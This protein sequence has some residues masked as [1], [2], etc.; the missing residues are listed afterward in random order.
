MATKVQKIDDV[1]VIDGQVYGTSE[2]DTLFEIEKVPAKGMIGQF[3]RALFSLF[4]RRKTDIMEDFGVEKSV[5]KGLKYLFY[6]TLLLPMKI[7]AGIVNPRWEYFRVIE[8][9][10]TPVL[11]F[12]QGGAAFAVLGAH[13]ERLIDIMRTG[14]GEALKPDFSSIEQVLYAFRFRRIAALAVAAVLLF[15]G[16]ALIVEAA[17]A[18][19]VFTGFAAG[20]TTATAGGDLFAMDNP[21]GFGDAVAGIGVGVIVWYVIG[22]VAAAF[23]AYLLMLVFRLF[24]EG[25]RSIFWTRSEDLEMFI[26]DA[27]DYTAAKAAEIYGPQ[28]AALALDML[29]ENYVLGDERLYN[30]F[31]KM[32]DR[33][34]IDE[35]KELA[36]TG[37]IEEEEEIED[38]DDFDDFD[39][40]FDEGDSDGK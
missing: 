18:I 33:R 19:G 29:F 17:D 11:N 14:A 5:F 6:F 39:D 28:A 24:G 35:I 27:L 36:K 37:E 2:R 13:Y 30:H 38:G 40:D 31:A 3:F 1:Q 22:I 25:V 10:T 8:K 21:G 26:I 9:A 20:L 16:W 34:R 15:A 23:F 32:D 12:V 7:L 4:T